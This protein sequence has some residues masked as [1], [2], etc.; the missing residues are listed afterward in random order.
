MLSTATVNPSTI[1]NHSPNYTIRHILNRHSLLPSTFSLLSKSNPYSSFFPYRPLCVRA[2]D[3]AQLF[4]YES[5]LTKESIVSQHLKIA[6]VG[7]GNFG[8]FLAATL[9]CQGHSVLA[10]SYSDH[11][12]TARNLVYCSSKTPTTYARSIPNCSSAAL[13]SLTSSLS[14]N[15]PKLLLELL[16]SDF[17]VL[18][19]HSMFGPK[20]A[21]DG[22]TGLSFVFKKLRILDEEHRVSRCEKFLNAFFREGCRMVEM[23]CEDHDRYAAGSQILEGLMLESTPIN[24]KGYQSL[25]GLVENTAGDS[26]DLYFGLFM[27]N[28]N[29][30]EMLEKLDLAFLDLRKQAIARLHHVVRN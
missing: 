3:S 13:S 4:D 20:F 18:C 7:F 16:P 17:D 19:T 30:L 6:I 8:R 21:S 24:T 2:N 14:K 26:F 27:F 28:K 10:Y 29:S 9:V 22:W 23:S 1:F 12:A 15:S 5:K 25:L 11:S